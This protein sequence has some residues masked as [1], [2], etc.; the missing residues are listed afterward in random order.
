MPPRALLR[1]LLLG[2]SVTAALTLLA[3]SRARAFCGFYVAGAD[4]KLVADAT[5]VVLMREGTKTVLSM[6]NDYKG[7]PERFALVIPVPVV[8]TKESVKVLPREVFDKVDRLGA[9]RLVEYWEQDPC[10]Q[11]LGL[12]GIGEGGGGAGTGIGLGAVGGRGDVARDLG[13]RVEAKF[14]VGEYEVVILSAR[15]AAGLDTWL[16]QEKYAIPSGAEPFFRP[17]V[18][19][20]MKFFVA[21]VD[22]AKVRFEGGRATLSPLRFH[23][24]SATFSLPVRLGLINS[25]GKQDL[26]VNVLARHQRFEVANYPNATIPTN[27]D[28]SDATRGRFGEFYAALF[29][30]T[31]A[32]TPRA[33]VTEYAWDAGTCDPCPGPTLDGNDLATLGAD[34]LPDGTNGLRPAGAS[35]VSSGPRPNVRG[36]TPTNTGGLPPPVVDRVV[37][38]GFGRFRACY[39]RG[40]EASPKGAGRVSTRIT[41]DASGAVSKAE[42]AGTTLAGGLSDSVRACIQ[43]SFAA[44]QFPD[45]SGG[46]AVTLTYALVLTPGDPGPPSPS[47]LGG[48]GG[49]GGFARQASTPYVLTRMHLRYDATSLGDDLVFRAAPAIAGGRE[50]R[51]SGPDGGLEQ[52]AMPASTNNFQGRYAIRHSWAGPIAC[53]EP[54]RGVWGP[55]PASDTTGAAPSTPRVAQK[56]AFATRGTSLAVFLPGGP[57]VVP[58]AA[59]SANLDAATAPSAS[60]PPPPAGAPPK[61]APPKKG[62]SIAGVPPRGLPLEPIAGATIIAAALGFAARRRARSQEKI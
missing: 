43:R 14:G 42:D 27:L 1:P 51:G 59:D 41:I 34:V 58:G 49:L 44:L 55:R 2:A 10:P 60:A 39:A 38:Q 54:R 4:A 20:G 25:S 37:R 30:D 56:T 57:P 8:L 18:A 31:V 52:G 22:P 26:I 48:V 62:C 35:A 7:P 15:D 53:K 21:K 32:K 33:V 40:L 3:A 61:E 17:Y 36:E 6:Q 19:S 29:D 50:S 5:Q 46:R 24:D 28:V 16:K 47:S 13:V 45:P 12:S 11:A 9:P 23:Y